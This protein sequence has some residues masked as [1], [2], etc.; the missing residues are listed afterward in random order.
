MISDAILYTERKKHSNSAASSIN[1][2]ING[3]ILVGKLK[4]IFTSKDLIRCLIS[5]FD[6]QNENYLVTLNDE[7][8]N[9]VVT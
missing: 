6:K 9:L 3:H 1:T 8:E 5:E 7:S 4:S 2:P